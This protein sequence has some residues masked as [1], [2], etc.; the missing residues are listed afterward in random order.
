[1]WAIQVCNVNISP[2]LSRYAPMHNLG[3]LLFNKFT[4]LSIEN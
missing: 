3:H 4:I 1:M 2:L